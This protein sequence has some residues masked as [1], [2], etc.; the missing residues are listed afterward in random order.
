[1]PAKTP[2][3]REHLF[4]LL[5]HDLTS[6]LSVISASTSRLL[7]HVA[8]SGSLTERETS[9]L[10]RILRNAQ[11]SQIILQEMVEILRSEAGLFRTDAFAVDAMLRE[12]IL[13]VLD[14]DSPETADALAR[15]QHPSRFP[16]VLEA[17]GIFASI[18]GKYAEAPFP[19]D[20][21]KVQQILRNL[22]SN[23]LKHRRQRVTVTLSGDADLVVT[24]EDDGPG[25]PEK[26]QRSIFQRFVQLSGDTDR[27]VAGLGLGLA[28]VKALVGAMGGR[29]VFVSREGLGTR[30]SVGIPPLE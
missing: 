3:D 10:E 9:A 22:V 5:V 13:E 21:R 7:R 4:E 24:V 23:A 12:A 14:V 19:H 15:E 29:I 28:G 2:S 1:M 16:A 17:H 25:I 8:R 30:F 26:E 6:P 20:R 18:S 11:R 27:S